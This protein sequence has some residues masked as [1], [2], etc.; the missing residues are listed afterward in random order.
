M[1]ALRVLVPLSQIAAAA[2]A[3]LVL[4]T[5]AQDISILYQPGNLVQNCDLNLYVSQGMNLRVI[6]TSGQLITYSN[7]AQSV[8]QFHYSPDGAAIFEDKRDSNPGG[9]VYVSNSEVDNNQG[10]V[11]GLCKFPQ[12]LLSSSSLFSSMHGDC[13]HD[14]D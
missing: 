13:D 11:G 14:D 2:S 3:F 12:L 6:A 5:F 7:G 9:Y 10:G 8:N 1:K 4:V